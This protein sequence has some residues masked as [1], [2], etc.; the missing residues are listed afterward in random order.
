MLT[1]FQK[2]K[3]S[4]AAIVLLIVSFFAN[5][6]PKEF[7][8]E[9]FAPANITP[10]IKS[11]SANGNGALYCSISGGCSLTVNGSDFYDGASVFVGPYECTHQDISPD[12]NSINCIVGPGKSG[13]FQVTVINKDT[14]QSAIDPTVNPTTLNFSYASF[15]YLGV[16]D[17]PGKVYGYAQNPET[18]ALL[19]IV[20]S[21]FSITGN[22]QTYGTVISPNNRF[23]YA[24]NVSSGTI[25]V[26][27]INSVNGAL[28]QVGNPVSSGAASPNGLFFHPSGNFLYV[29]NQ[30]GNSVSAFSVASDGTLTAVA[31]SPFSSGGPS[32]LNGIVVHPDGNYLYVASMGGTG[33]VVGYSIDPATG[34]LALLP[35][36]P[37]KNTNG[38]FSNTGDGITI[39]PNGN[40]LYMG[41]VNQKRVAAF[42]ID[43]STGVLTGLGT[44]VLNNSTTG[45]TDNGGS[46]ANVSPDGLYFYGTAFS[47]TGTHPKKVI[48]YEINQLTGDLSLSSEA[49]ARDR[50]PVS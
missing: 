18:G 11:I 37:F 21:P 1:L 40:W 35:G 41:M 36:S 26:Y 3:L 30:G 5:C 48:V 28:T 49:D 7:S 19:P 8:Q 44:P 27:Q 38:G 17:S 43:K 14:H 32:L 46:G 47:T 25:S 20:G 12:H 13:V 9:S 15:L 4:V 24:A 50:S 34:A 6:S 29:T 42:S 39:H 10:I 31:G 33:G 16:Q 22:N 2:N 45:Y 23:L